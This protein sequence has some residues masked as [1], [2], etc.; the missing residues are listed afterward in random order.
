MENI[1][2]V[3]LDRFVFPDLYHLMSTWYPVSW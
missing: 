2:K 1:T 3:L